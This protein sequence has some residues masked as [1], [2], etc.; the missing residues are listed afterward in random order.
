MAARV[1][2]ASGAKRTDEPKPPSK[3]GEALVLACMDLRVVDDA[4]E[5]LHA[6]GRAKGAKGKSGGGLRDEY[7]YVTL[8]G[9]ALGATTRLK[10]HWNETFWDHLGL[11]VQLHH[12]QRVIIVEHQD[13]G[14]YKAFYE[15][16]RDRK[17]VG[18]WAQREKEK[19]L[20]RKVAK[21]LAARIQREYELPVELLYAE[22]KAPDSTVFSLVKL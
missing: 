13:C 18:D 16:E 21:E 1:K 9:A 5:Y 15:P 8:A 4:V 12:I 10:P 6:K 19:E 22:L 11:A 14:A 20:H 7:D 17:V 3:I 2:P